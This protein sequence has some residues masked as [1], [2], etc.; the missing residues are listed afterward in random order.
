MPSGVRTLHR[1]GVDHQQDADT[2][3]PGHEAPRLAP[4]AGGEHRHQLVAGGV[5]AGA[6]S[7]WSTMEKSKAPVHG[8]SHSGRCD[9]PPLDMAAHLTVCSICR[10]WRR[11]RTATLR[12]LS[13][14]FGVSK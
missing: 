9:R 1:A 4:E 6:R 11:V 12:A 10:P 2:P 7:G 3:G 14:S 5:R 13:C 8:C